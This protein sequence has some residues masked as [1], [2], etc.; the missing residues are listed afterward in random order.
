MP[1]LGVYDVFSASLAAR[2]SDALFMSG[3]GFAASHYGLPDIGFISWTDMVDFVGRVRAVLPSH[4][5]L[6]DIDDGYCD[7]E[8]ACHV[9]SRLERIG[10]SGVVLEDQRRPRRCGHFDGTQIMELDEFLE[11][12]SRVLETRGDLFVVA[13]TDATDAA[14]A[15]RRVRAF[16]DAGA[17]AVLIDGVPEFRARRLHVVS[18]SMASTA[19][20]IPPTLGASKKVSSESSTRSRR[21]TRATNCIASIESPPARKKSSSTPA[22][23]RPSTSV[24][25]DATISSTGVAGGVI[26]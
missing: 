18:V 4:H 24:Q 12:L 9:A 19:A 1:F 11:K 7:T 26:V 21:P 25:I 20:A 10:A 14:E 23:S 5:L 6:V 15:A 16:A 22:G 2:H 17:D 3:F 8:V 13:R